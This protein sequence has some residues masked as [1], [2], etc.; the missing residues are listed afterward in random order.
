LI[1]KNKTE[2]TNNQPQ[3][4]VETKYSN[5]LKNTNCKLMPSL[6]TE[7]TYITYNVKP[8]DTLEIIAKEYLSNTSNTK[9]LLE[10]NKRIYKSLETSSI[11]QP[12][13]TLYIPIKD[14]ENTE[15]ILLGIHGVALEL[16]PN[17]IIY[18]TEKNNPNAYGYIY[19]DDKTLIKGRNNW[20]DLLPG[21]CIMSIWD[22][23]KQAPYI[24]SVQ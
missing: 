22:N 11:L 4:T 1:I 18:S 10:I 20:T 7:E 16:T 21:D 9:G 5:I 19:P 17:S 2:S 15:S 6:K 12:G 8:G 23:S 13:W 3:T 24:I 14:Y